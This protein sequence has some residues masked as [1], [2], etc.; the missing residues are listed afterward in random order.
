M[1]ERECIN[2]KVAKELFK[3]DYTEWCENSY[4]KGSQITDYAIE[5]Y[6]ELTDDGYYELTKSGGGTEPW[7]KI[8]DQRFRFTY[9]FRG[10]NGWFKEEGMRAMSAPSVYEVQRWLREEHGIIVEVR[11]TGTNKLF[12]TIWCKDEDIYTSHSSQKMFELK[13]YY[14]CFN[15]ALYVTFKYYFGK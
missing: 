4:A 13:D 1:K 11:H 7:G 6:G 3:T 8:Y 10:S 5:K 14:K 2:L 12:Y 15:E 9:G